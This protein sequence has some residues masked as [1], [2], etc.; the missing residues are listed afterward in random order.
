MATYETAYA[1]ALGLNEDGTFTVL[2]TSD[3]DSTATTEGTDPVFVEGEE[4]TIDTEANTDQLQTTIEGFFEDGYVI[5]A[6][7]GYV[8]FTNTQYA[9]NFEFALDVNSDGTSVVLPVCFTA[10]TLIDT[11]NGPVAIEDIKI[12]DRVLGSS[13]YRPVKW[14]GRRNYILRSPRLSEA[15]RDGIV[16]VRIKAHAL[17]DNVPS[18]D[19]V[20]SPWHHVYI[21]NV[22]IK[23]GEL[24]NGRTVVR[25]SQISRVTYFHIELDQFDVVRAHNMYSE[26]WADGGNRD[27][28]ENVDVT[29]L[30]P[31]DQMRRRADRPGF[32]VLRAKDPKL[33]SIKQQILLRAVQSGDETESALAA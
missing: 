9:E 28:F 18:R 4:V 1:S 29:A 32:T 16:P 24:V 5:F 12:G 27:F 3:A 14:I 25:E 17:A 26:S 2:A 7:G 22:L 8:L 13:G 15:H 21:D 23:A 19:I 30:R 6:D 31:E 10:G 11:P 33:A 20:L